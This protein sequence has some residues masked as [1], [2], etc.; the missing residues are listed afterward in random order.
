M[1]WTRALSRLIAKGLKIGNPIFVRFLASKF[2][3]RQKV[4]I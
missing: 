4:A 2:F 3:D 1:Y